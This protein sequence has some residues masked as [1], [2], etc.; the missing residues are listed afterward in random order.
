MIFIIS[1]LFNNQT[2]KFEKP[3]TLETF[4]DEEMNLARNNL[5][6]EAN[7]RLVDLSDDKDL[8]ID[9]RSF[10]FPHLERLSVANGS[11]ED[12]HKILTLTVGAS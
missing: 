1:E 6:A 8:P 9:Q 2:Q 10:E 4:K 11:A 3:D 12:M 5:V 7:A